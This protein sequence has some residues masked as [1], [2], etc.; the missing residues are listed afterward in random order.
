MKNVCI[1]RSRPKPMTPKQQAKR[2]AAGETFF[3]S[4]IARKKAPLKSYSRPD[5][6]QKRRK[7]VKKKPRSENERERIYGTLEFR[8]WLHRQCCAVC[9]AQAVF[10]EQAHAVGGGAGRKAGWRQTFPMCGVRRDLL[11]GGCHGEAHRIGVKTFE[12]KYGITLAALA[13]QTQAKWLSH[14]SSG[15]QVE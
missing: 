8:D 5:A 2:E 3:G 10:T 7:P 11:R 14:T 6:K 12:A 4:S 15:A 1:R 13:E 9:G